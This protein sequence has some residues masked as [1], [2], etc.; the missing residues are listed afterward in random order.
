MLVGHLGRQGRE[1]DHAAL[2]I[3]NY[4]LGGNGAIWKRVHPELAPARAEGHFD[5][6]LFVESRGKRGLSNDIS[7]YVPV[8][9]RTR[10]LAYAVTL[11]RPES[12]AYLLKIIDDEWRKVREDVSDGD[13][14]IAKDALSKGYFQMRYAGAHATA[15]TLAEEHLLEGGHEWSER[16]RRAHPVRD[17]G[18]GD[19]G[20]A[21]VLP[22]RGARG[23]ARG[24]HRRDPH[25]RAPSLQGEARGLRRDRPASLVGHGDAVRR[26]SPSRLALPTGGK[27]HPAPSGGEE[28]DRVPDCPVPRRGRAVQH[29]CGDEEPHGTGCDR[30]VFEPRHGALRH[31]TH[32]SGL[33]PSALRGLDRVASRIRGADRARRGR[34][35]APA[36]SL[37]RRLSAAH[38]RLRSSQG[39]RGVPVPPGQRRRAARR[40][41]RRPSTASSRGS[42]GLA[43]TCS[44]SSTSCATTGSGGD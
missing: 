14:A 3:A 22:P 15:L 23:G 43:T 34:D 4:I 10:G 25:V 31:G 2:E 39:A 6:R 8:G 27:V 29:R 11:G 7:S 19:G 32:L 41:P 16:L 9:F 37:R 40:R 12:I 17:E 20:G 33:R 1:D 36:R 13:I 30:L 18:R 38:S 44:S 35:R 21:E 26:A 24:A 42:A 5:A 28:D